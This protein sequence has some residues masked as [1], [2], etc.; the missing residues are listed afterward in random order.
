[1]YY[2]V[3]IVVSVPPPHQASGGAPNGAESAKQHLSI[4]H[5][6]S[7]N[8]RPARHPYAVP[9]GDL[10]GVDPTTRPER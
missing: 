9:E 2:E 6:S 10:L 3:S 1:M 7:S 4:T 8:C 5:L